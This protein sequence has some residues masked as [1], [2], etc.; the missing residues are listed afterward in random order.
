MRHRKR[1]ALLFLIAA[2]LVGMRARG[3]LAARGRAASVDP[4]AAL[5][6]AV[7]AEAANIALAAS[8]ARSQ[9]QAMNQGRR[10]QWL[11]QC[12]H[13]PK[14]EPWLVDAIVDGAPPE[15]Q[16][17]AVR[18]S[19]A[20]TSE[21]LA[22][23][24]T[25][26]E[27]KSAAAAAIAEIVA[28]PGMGAALLGEMPVTTMADA[29]KSP[30]RARGKSMK[31]TGR[32]VEVHARDGFFEGILASD[33]KTSV[34]FFTEM[35]MRGIRVGAPVT[36]RGVFLGRDADGPALVVGGFDTPTPR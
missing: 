35:S 33:T 25:N 15:D 8:N 24:A 9:S 16:R 36:Y 23:T 17:Q 10:L 3:A 5:L 26:E 1:L 28:R 14:C 21:E 18:A 6:A 27:K 29:S 20:A 7:D 11:R 22:A 34:R 13:P 30:D 4:T 32:L 31:V 12:A 19:F 2:V